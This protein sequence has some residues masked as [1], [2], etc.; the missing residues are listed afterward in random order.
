MMKTDQLVGNGFA[1]HNSTQTCHD[2]GM[3]CCRSHRGVSAKEQQN[4][5]QDK[6]SD[7]QVAC[8]QLQVSQ[9]IGSP[10]ARCRS[11]SSCCPRTINK[12]VVH[13]VAYKVL[14]IPSHVLPVMVAGGSLALRD[15]ILMMREHL[16]WRRMLTESAPAQMQ[17]A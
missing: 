7:A 8:C 15:L 6:V 4:T 3:L 12:A 13:P 16:H 11:A 2:K 1:N 14:A 5:C 17:H 10:A 9:A